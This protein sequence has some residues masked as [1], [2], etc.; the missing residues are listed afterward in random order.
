MNWKCFDPKQLQTITMHSTDLQTKGV[1]STVCNSWNVRPWD[2]Q[3]RYVN[4]LLTNAVYTNNEINLE[5][6][7]RYLYVIFS[8]S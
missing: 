8:C 3:K 6:K 7:S 2:P 4:M 5:K 1:K